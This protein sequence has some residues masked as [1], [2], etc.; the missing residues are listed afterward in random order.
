MCSIVYALSCEESEDRKMENCIDQCRQLGVWAA[1]SGIQI[2]KN[3]NFSC[4]VNVFIASKLKYILHYIARIY[5]G[6]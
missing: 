1:N 4:E 3:N 6:T 5:I 2:F